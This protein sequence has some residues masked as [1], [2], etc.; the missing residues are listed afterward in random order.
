MN[1]VE[2]KIWNIVSS[3]GRIPPPLMGYTLIQTDNR[4]Y[5]VSGKILHSV[6]ETDSLYVLYPGIYILFGMLKLCNF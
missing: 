3:S 5:V 6:K 1:V 4:V 2:N